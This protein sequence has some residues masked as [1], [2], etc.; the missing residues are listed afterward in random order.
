MDEHQ[1]IAEGDIVDH[2]LFGLGKV[3]AVDDRGYINGTGANGN[4]H[5]VT[6]AW[7]DPD[8][9]ECT[10]MNWALKKVSSPDVRPF[11][12]WEKQWQPLRE[13]WL[14]ARREVELLCKTFEPAPEWRRL[15]EAIEAE[16]AAW[17]RMKEFIDAPRT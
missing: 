12:F 9:R 6:V 16:A 15:D 13:D 11:I 3:Q 1:K 14:K 2:K 8:R 4:G 17:V 5:P 7:D 10:V